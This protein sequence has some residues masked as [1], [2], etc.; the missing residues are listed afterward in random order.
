MTVKVHALTRLP[1]SAW[2]CVVAL[3][4]AGTAAAC[5]SDT[6]NNE[7]VTLTYINTTPADT[8]RVRVKVGGS[9]LGTYNLN[10][11]GAQDTWTALG[12]N[13]KTGVSVNSTVLDPL[14]N[15]LA[16]GVCTVSDAPTLSY[17]RILITP[18]TVSCDCGFAEHGGAACG[19]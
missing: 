18:S 4:A 9:T 3:G 8:L 13:L 16:V 11:A 19:P 1:R 12:A 5:S 6:Q 2:L 10:A 7:L 14:G 17:A 15:T